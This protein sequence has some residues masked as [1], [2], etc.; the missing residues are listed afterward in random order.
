MAGRGVQRVGQEG[1]SS[2]CRLVPPSCVYCRL[3]VGPS[4]VLPLVGGLIA[5]KMTAIPR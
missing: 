5:R 2:R 1:G 3:R 4:E